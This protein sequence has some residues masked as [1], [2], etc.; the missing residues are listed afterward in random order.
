MTREGIFWDMVEG[1]VPVHPVGR[2]LGIEFTA[3]DPEAGTVDTR[4]QVG[5]DFVNPFGTVHGGILTT[6]LDD[7]MSPALVA[8]LGPDDATST[9]DMHVNF[10]SV[11]RPGRFT[12]SG[13]VV[14]R[15]RRIANLAGELRDEE[16]TLVATADAVAQIRPAGG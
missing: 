8:T 3:I 9:V 6:M 4:F 11:A 5:P 14:R 10:L 12:G 16:G 15:G 1:R 7:T 2:S 13:R